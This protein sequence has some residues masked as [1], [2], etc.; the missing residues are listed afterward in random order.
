MK[1][2][3][4]K[5]TSYKGGRLQRRPYLVNWLIVKKKEKKNEA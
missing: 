4:I 1:K 5:E 3:K 2:N